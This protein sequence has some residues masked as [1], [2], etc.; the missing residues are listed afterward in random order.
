MFIGGIR[1]EITE[2][3]IK[4]VFEPYGVVTNVDLIKD[5]ATGN[6][7][8]FGFV[9]FEDYDSVDKAVCMYIWI[10]FFVCCLTTN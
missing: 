5:R 9:T 6:L 1:G 10:H 3:Q 7:R 2:E 8:G 4:E